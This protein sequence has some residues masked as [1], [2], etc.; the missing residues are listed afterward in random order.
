MS[1]SM[2]DCCFV[3]GPPP[4]DYLC[5]IGVKVL[6]EPHLTDCC[7]QH[8]CQVCLE[9]LFKKQ[10]KKACP[11]CR[12]ESFSFI[13][14]VYLP[15]KRKIDML[16]VYCSNREEGCQM[17]VQLSELNSHKGVCDYTKVRC[18][19]G[20]EMVILRKDVLQHCNSDCPKRMIKC[21][22]CGKEDHFKAITGE[23]TAVCKEYPVDCP[24]GCKKETGIKRKNLAEHAEI[25]PCLLY[26][27]PSP[28]DAT[29]SRM[30]SSA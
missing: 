22:H 17:T 14:L 27:S 6:N 7:G 26:T 28:R 25:C 8:F 3:K 15:L 16:E 20:C 13:H 9:Q 4:D 30:P 5:T 1:F 12:S 24:K 23:H 21:K 10:G 2:E 19:Q 18:D 29:L 11:H